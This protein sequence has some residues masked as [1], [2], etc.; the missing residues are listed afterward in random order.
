MSNNDW[1]YEYFYGKILA[2]TEK[3]FTAID[4]L[5]VALEHNLKK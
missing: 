1:N 3:Q 2:D 5:Q 4:P